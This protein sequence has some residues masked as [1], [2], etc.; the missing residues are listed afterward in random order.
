[1][2]TRCLLFVGFVARWA[3]YGMDWSREAI[4]V[5]VEAGGVYPADSPLPDNAP[6]EQKV[7]RWN[8][9]SRRRVEQQPNLVGRFQASAYGS[10]NGQGCY[11]V[12]TMT[13]QT[14]HILNGQLVRRKKRIP[15]QRIAVENGR[16][17]FYD[18]IAGSKGSIRDHQSSA[19]SNLAIGFVRV[20]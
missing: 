19:S 15:R 9:I 18:F 6:R 17:P 14:W 20:P 10:P 11:I 5:D 2:R 8:R 1:M 7:D 3:A 13:G 12:D 4:A 16:M